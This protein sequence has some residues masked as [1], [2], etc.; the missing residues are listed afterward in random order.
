MYISAKSI[1]DLMRKVL[2][3]L[4]AKEHRVKATRGSAAEELGVLLKVRNPRCR[5]S[6]TETR[7]Q[8]FSAIGELLWYLAG[9]KDGEFITYYAPGYKK[10]IVNG[11]IYGGYGPRL[12]R[13]RTSDG[14]LTNQIENVIQVLTQKRGSRRA[15]IQLFDA[16]D[17][18]DPSRKEVPCTCTLQ[19]LIRGD[20]LHLIS[21]L[22]SNDA[23]LGLP[24]DVFAFTM[25]QEILARRL[26]LEIGTYKHMV[27]SL[28]LYDKQDGTK[29]DWPALAQ[30]YLDEGF[31]EPVEM[32]AM[33]I[34]DPMPEIN[35]LLLLEA[36][37]RN[38]KRVPA[39]EFKRPGY[40]GD[41][42]RLLKIFQHVKK[43]EPRAQRAIGPL[44]AR[45]SSRFFH[46]YIQRKQR[47]H[48][49]VPIPKQMDFGLTMPP[50]TAPTKAKEKR[51]PPR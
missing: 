10:D 31:P 25:L 43:K 12:I 29:E 5:L 48:A 35:R 42:A 36:K 15:V 28:H 30:Q 51:N 34:G 8:L 3:L 50:P 19:F 11:E 45:M 47:P 40:W 22:R 20:R 26:G 14:S 13:R 21:S 38:R 32:P 6:R 46:I 44:K 33:P 17:I 18:V 2:T 37:L 1:D 49:A 39:A 24:H 7:G 23:Y 16:E 27:G 9:S 4:L 41:L